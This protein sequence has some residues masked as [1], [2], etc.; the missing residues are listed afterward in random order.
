[1]NRD[2]VN[3][4]ER[5]YVFFAVNECSKKRDLTILHVRFA[6]CNL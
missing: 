6:T 3:N 4:A 5:C 1:M 2:F